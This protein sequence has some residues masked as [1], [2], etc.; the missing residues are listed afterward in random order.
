MQHEQ[1]VHLT[2]QVLHEPHLV[3]TSM[4]SPMSKTRVE[5]NIPP[6][7][8]QTTGGAQEGRCGMSTLFMDQV[9]SVAGTGNT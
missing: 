2:E 9:W 1:Q 5:G 4:G 7:C 8:L 3:A 6:T